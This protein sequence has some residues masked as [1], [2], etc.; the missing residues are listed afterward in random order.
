[1]LSLTVPIKVVAAV[2]G[3]LTIET[4]DVAQIIAAERAALVPLILVAV[5]VAIIT[6]TLLTLGIARPVRKLAIASDRVRIGASGETRPRQTAQPQG[7]DR[8]PCP[9][10]G[11]DDRLAL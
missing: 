1:M 10:D 8:R 6:S 2:V 7:R 3:A 9:R 5:L 4:S 11:G